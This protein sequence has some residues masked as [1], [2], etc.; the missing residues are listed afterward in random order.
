MP[1]S[2]P[3]PGA[4][5]W[6]KITGIVTGL[7]ALLLILMLAT[8]AGGHGA[9]HGSPA[10]I[11]G[12]SGGYGRWG[13]PVLLAVLLLGSMALNS[14]RL[15]ERSSHS[16]GPSMGMPPLWRKFVLVAHVSS[17]VAALGAVAVFLVLAVVGLASDNA[18]FVR[19]AYVANAL[20]AW[21]VILPLLIAS[22]VIGVGQA[23]ATPWGLFRHYWVV[24]KLALTIV[25]VYVLLQQMDGISYL[26]E[27]A[28]STSLSASD[29]RG[30]RHSVQIHAAGGLVV[31]LVL[32]AL[33]IYKPRGLTRYGWRKQ[34]EGA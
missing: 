30:L 5:R 24:A 19:A 31:L 17:S 16:R 21:Y 12:A 4:P 29:L 34:Y 11:S 8:G 3:Y 7:L 1:D 18:E 20:I 2:P 13:L 14:R 23:L 22:L 33:S 28:A 25:T 10:E 9:A 15:V 26:A 27:V 6:V 32:V